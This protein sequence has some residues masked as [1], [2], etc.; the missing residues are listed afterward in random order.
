MQ[1]NK[2]LT[3]N[4]ISVGET[5]KKEKIGKG[6]YAVVYRINDI[7]KKKFTHENSNSVGV[8][9]VSIRELVVLKLCNHPNVIKM[10]DYDKI[11]FNWFTMPYYE[12][13]LRKFIRNSSYNQDLIMD[14]AKQLLRGAHYLHSIGVCHRDIKPQNILVSQKSK[15]VLADI[16]LARKFDCS[17][18]DT[19][20]T[21]TVCTLWYRAPE[22]LLGGK[23]YYN[24]DVWSIGCVIVEMF[25]KKPLFPGDSDTDQIFKIFRISGTPNETNWPGVTQLRNFK[26]TFP[27]WENKWNEKIRPSI[28]SGLNELLE[29]MLCMNPNKRLCC[30]QALSLLNESTS[31]CCE[32]YSEA[33]IQWKFPALSF[34]M[35][36][37][38]RKI[39][40][41]W[42]F[43]VKL[44]YHLTLPCYIRACNIVDRYTSLHKI[45]LRDFQLVGVSALLISSKIE[46]IFAISI[47]D[48]VY[49]S[50]NTY[51]AD[52]V[53]EMEKEI[54]RS[55]DLDLYF[56]IISDFI[57][58]YSEKLE[59][60]N[61][62]QKELEFLLS[63]VLFSRE[64]MLYHPSIITLCLCLYIN[65][66]HDFVINDDDEIHDCVCDVINWLESGIKVNLGS[67]NAIKNYYSKRINIEKYM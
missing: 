36:E 24:I 64:I 15:F 33:L 13:D 58:L 12:C 60:S 8:Q 5:G 66:T 50:D 25:L 51:N 38:C 57:Y 41:D 61:E 17:S 27:V 43:D 46:E 52:Q 16:G 63:Y 14:A 7:A 59:L 2:Q 39:L 32:N 11:N 31:N 42:L 47:E 20:K 9:S 23:Y 1:P 37:Q 53:S 44:E 10:L 62:Q 55:F 6:T 48:M 29:G 49:I 30:S 3:D 54:L 19:S 18:S 4:E 22:I 45:E 35:G 21:R 67:L 28:D 56:P 40:F 65:K 34:E 26:N